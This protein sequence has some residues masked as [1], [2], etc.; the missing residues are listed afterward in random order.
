MCSS[1]PAL[2]PLQLPTDVYSHGLD[3]LPWQSTFFKFSFTSS[4]SIKVKTSMLQILHWPQLP[5]SLEKQSDPKPRR[6]WS[7]FLVLPCVLY[8]HTAPLTWQWAHNFS[9]LPFT[10]EVLTGK[11][12]VSLQVP[13]QI[14]IQMV[15][16]LLNPVLACSNRASLLFPSHLPFFHLLYIFISHLSFF[17]T[18]LSIRAG[19]LLSLSV[20][21]LIRIDEKD[22]IDDS[23][24]TN[25]LSRT[26]LSS[27]AVTH[28]I[29]PGR[30][31]NRQKSALLKS[32][33]SF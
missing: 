24:K 26:P 6:S 8:H 4:S 10:G 1:T 17:R 33:G 18:S 25:H 5:E 14:Q 16:G 23:F 29:F 9:Y 32:K 31:L 27:R 7:K 15:F 2:S 21:F 22:E 20:F 30:P 3:T 19:L 11:F 28:G 13:G 12:L